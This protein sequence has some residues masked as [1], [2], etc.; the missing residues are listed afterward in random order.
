MLKVGRGAAGRPSPSGLVPPAPRAN[1]LEPRQATRPR[2]CTAPRAR[3][4][5]VK[6]REFWSLIP[7]SLARISIA[8]NPLNPPFYTPSGAL[9][10]PRRSWYVVRKEGNSMTISSIAG[11]IMG[12]RA[13]RGALELLAITALT[14]PLSLVAACSSDSETSSTSSRP[15][16]GP[17][18]TTSST[19]SRR[20]ASRPALPRASPTSSPRTPRATGRT[21]STATS[22]A[23]RRS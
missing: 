2:C 11:H 3:L 18:I 17:I 4:A 7:G 21:I 10:F 23:G 15:S 20:T 1:C 6:P 16:T 14:A 9:P 12:S 5:D 13:G 8:L 19:S 22:R